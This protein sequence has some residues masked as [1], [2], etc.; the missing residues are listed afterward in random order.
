MVY[1][2]SETRVRI[3]EPG[4]NDPPVKLM[5]TGVNFFILYMLQSAEMLDPSETPRMQNVTADWLDTNLPLKGVCESQSKYKQGIGIFVAITVIC[6]GGVIFGT[7]EQTLTSVLEELNCCTKKP[8]ADDAIRA[9]LQP[10]TKPTPPGGN[11]RDSIPE[12]G[13]TAFELVVPPPGR[14]SV[15]L[16]PGM[17]DTTPRGGRMTVTPPSPVGRTSLPSVTA[18]RMA[19]A[20]A[21]LEPGTNIS[22]RNFKRQQTG[23]INRTSTLEN[24]QRSLRA[25][26]ARGKLCLFA[27]YLLIVLCMML[28]FSFTPFYS[29]D[30]GGVPRNETGWRQA[31]DTNEIAVLD[32]YGLS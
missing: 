32:L 5:M 21:S 14:M 2:T 16:P 18:A 20:R 17:K 19:H 7:S 1:L 28:F 13:I 11:R 15:T 6:L 4:I 29:H 31:C 26:K 30:N 25:D 23:A 9:S 27:S 22:A 24:Q 8:S 3:D 12:D 10:T